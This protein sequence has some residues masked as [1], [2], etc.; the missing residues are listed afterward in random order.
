MIL[1]FVV[2]MVW[3]QLI[4]TNL[5][6]PR[7]QQRK[8]RTITLP[9]NIESLGMRSS[10]TTMSIAETAMF[11][12]PAQAPYDGLYQRQRT[13]LPQAEFVPQ[14]PQIPSEP[15]TNLNHRQ[16]DQPQVC[17]RSSMHLLVASLVFRIAPRNAT[18][19]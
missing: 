7:M 1:P 19:V 8:R 4:C 6:R 16:Y 14:A 3:L 13:G 5:R 18:F 10:R 2:R 17:C 12:S 9:V 11:V 15:S